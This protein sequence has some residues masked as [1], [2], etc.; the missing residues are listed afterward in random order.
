MEKTVYIGCGAGFAGDRFDASLPIVDSLARCDGPRYLSFELLAERTLAIAQRER[1]ADPSRGYSPFLDQYIEPVLARAQ[2][3]GVR[4]V[5]NM[6]AA[7]PRGAASRIL[8]IARE[9]GIDGLKV[10]V[11]EGDNLLDIMTE[12]DL[13]QAET[14]EGIAIGDRVILAANAY[15]GAYPIAEALATGADVVVTGRVTDPAII[16]GPLI[17]EFGWR[18]DD[19]NSLAGGTLAGHLLE[20]GAQVTGAYFADPGY[21]DVTDLARV[22]FP[23]AAV[24][25][26]GGM[27][28]SKPDGTGGLVSEQTV[29]EQI[30]YEM[31]DPSAYLTA[32]VVLDI[33]AVTIEQLAPH[34]VAVRGAR[35]HPRPTTLKATVSLEGGWL[36]EGEISYV[37]PNARRRAELAASV[38]RERCQLIGI[39]HPIRIDI[40]GT[41][42]TFD[43]VDGSLRVAG[44]F[45]DDGDYRVRAAIRAPDKQSAERLA[46]EVLSLYCS[47]PAGGGGVRQAVTRR[48]D[49]ASILVDRDQLTP[50]VSIVEGL[51]EPAS[52]AQAPAV[53]KATD[54]SGG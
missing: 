30:L 49:T 8:S 27:V 4:I 11:V 9:Q 45:A 24:E 36:G 29:K 22:G 3:A 41:L 48:V 51:P 13:R 37:G 17:H 54:R 25:A 50:R 28:I 23:I 16:L 43:S 38:I 20:C 52:R 42:S 5:S 6:G 7:N 26:D 40:I 46:D 32:D 12:A 18:E 47:G 39:E 31:H 19:W 35:G 10:A 1:R 21:K 2:A 14:V 33:T 34:R 44:E 53:P 15:L